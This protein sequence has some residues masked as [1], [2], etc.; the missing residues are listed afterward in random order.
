MLGSRPSEQLAEAPLSG[1]EFVKSFH[2]ALLYSMFRVILGPVWKLVPQGGYKAACAEAHGFIDY[3]IKHALAEQDSL[4]NKSLMRGLSAQTDDLDFIRS[5]VIQALMAAQDT[6]SELLTNVLFLLARHPEDWKRLRAEFAVKSQDDLTPET[7]RASKVTEN[8]LL[9]SKEIL[10]F[11]S[12]RRLT[13][14]G[15]I[16]DV[17][18]SALRLYPIFP[19]LGRV[20]LDNTTLPAGGGPDQDK[21]IFVPKGSTVTMA[22]YALH[23]NAEVF[24][25]DV[26]SFRPGR[27]DSVKP[28]QWEFLGFGGG[29]RACLGQQKAMIEASYVLAR[30]SQKFESLTPRD[31]RPW[32]GELKL[33]CKSAHGCMVTVRSA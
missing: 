7:V 22:Y 21:P 12:P 18:A 10:L 9:E 23:R 17:A 31:D 14:L 20:A 5:Q 6:T 28:G 30:F 29:N 1:D 13:V 26:E 24:G 32:E 4:N 3:C 15:K 2:K 16:T 27:W 19:L 33:T 25:A 8:I 11:S